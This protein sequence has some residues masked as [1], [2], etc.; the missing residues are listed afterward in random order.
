M[1]KCVCVCA[2]GGGFEGAGVSAA[3]GGCSGGVFGGA[4]GVDAVLDAFAGDVLREDIPTL[5]G[6][7]CC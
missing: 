2:K 1:N 6:E 5:V 4:E 7:G 3:G